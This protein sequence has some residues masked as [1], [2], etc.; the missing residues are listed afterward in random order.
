M[1]VAIARPAVATTV[2]RPRRSGAASSTSSWTSVAEWISSTATAARSTPS[3]SRSPAA[4]REEDE[5]RPQ[6]LAA[7]ADRRARVRG[8]H[9]AVRG[10]QLLEPLLE[11]RHQRRDVRATRL[12]EGEDLLGAAHRTVPAWMA[13]IPPAV[14]IQRTSVSP[15][16]PAAPPSASGP[17]KRLTELGRY[18]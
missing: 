6:P 12:D 2:G 9:L 14:R 4:G 10:R 17:G 13:M 5:Q 15:R 1:A 11:P 16:R 3:S 18:A 8:E 7:G